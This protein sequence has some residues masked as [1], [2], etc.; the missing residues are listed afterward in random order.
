MCWK[1]F[2]PFLSVVWGHLV[3]IRNS[4]LFCFVMSTVAEQ[5]VLCSQ[6]KEQPTFSWLAEWKTQRWE[7]TPCNTA[8]YTSGLA[9]VSKH[10]KHLKFF[11]QNSQS[12]Q[13]FGH[14][15]FIA[16]WCLSQGSLVMTGHIHMP[17]YFVQ[18]ALPSWHIGI[19][20]K[21]AP[22]DLI[23]ETELSPSRNCLLKASHWQHQLLVL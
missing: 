9:A 11:R 3:I 18:P 1:I 19:T 22:G 6:F 21:V 14:L 16:L 12:R 5:Q 2:L 8:L 10:T 15:L 4:P 20:T 17:E 23:H 7:N 13:D